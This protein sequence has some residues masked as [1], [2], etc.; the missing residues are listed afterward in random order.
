MN[1][2]RFALVGVLA[3]LALVA[4]SSNPFAPDPVCGPGINPG[5]VLVLDLTGYEQDEGRIAQA[6]QK[7]VG[8][9]RVM[10][11]S[12]VWIPKRSSVGKSG[13]SGSIASVQAISADWGCNLLLLLDSKMARNELKKQSRNESRVWLVQAGMRQ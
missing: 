9:Y 7:R 12:P 13:N 4:C 6:V 3:A 8:A 10:T 5:A 2:S 11:E 1:Y